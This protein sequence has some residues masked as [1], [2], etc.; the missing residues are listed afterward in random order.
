[1]YVG[2]DKIADIII[3]HAT[4]LNMSIFGGIMVEHD[5]LLN[6]R[7]GVNAISSIVYRYKKGKNVNSLNDA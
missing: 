2:I 4:I 1:M 3:N 6:L 7:T 5:K